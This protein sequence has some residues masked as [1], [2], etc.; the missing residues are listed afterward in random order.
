MFDGREK[1]EV[2]WV[3]KWYALNLLGGL[4]HPD[5]HMIVQLQQRYRGRGH[6]CAQLC[7]VLGM[8]RTATVLFF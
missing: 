3:C 5:V 8:F 7:S 4:C 6:V 2:L 1:R